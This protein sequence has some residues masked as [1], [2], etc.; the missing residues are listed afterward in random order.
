MPNQIIKFSCNYIKLLALLGLPKE[1]GSVTKAH[2]E[3]IAKDLTR[4]VYFSRKFSSQE[5]QRR[6]QSDTT[7]SSY[8]QGNIDC[9]LFTRL[10]AMQQTSAIIQAAQSVNPSNP[11]ITV[12]HFKELTE[13]GFAFV[14]ENDKD[15]ALAISYHPDV[16][17]YFIICY[18]RNTRAKPEE[19]EVLFY[20][21]SDADYY[22]DVQTLH[23]AHLGEA[24]LL[25]RASQLKQLLAINALPVEVQ[26]L[27]K[28]C[29]NQQGELLLEQIIKLKN[30]L[31]TNNANQGIQFSPEIA[32]A[33]KIEN[34][35]HIIESIF[36]QL[37]VD[38]A[39]PQ[40]DIAAELKLL[41]KR[42]EIVQQVNNKQMRNDRSGY[43]E[44]EQ[45]IKLALIEILSTPIVY[46]V[47]QKSIEGLDNKFAFIYQHSQPHLYQR[48]PL[49]TALS[50]CITLLTIACLSL[51]LTGIL[52][53]IELTLIVASNALLLL[54]VIASWALTNWLSNSN[55]Q[56]AQSENL[57]IQ[58]SLSVAHQLD[59]NLATIEFY[60]EN[61][62]HIEAAPDIP[63]RTEH[64]LLARHAFFKEKIAAATECGKAPSS[65]EEKNQSSS[66]VH[67]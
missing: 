37:P 25:P 39:S 49:T 58:E 26:L 66:Y 18:I 41:L 36:F 22:P 11:R 1:M 12:E 16:P 8:T 15:C 10:T 47:Y 50:S 2:Q 44:Q 63:N 27:L 20:Q 38:P 56:K 67:Q 48:Q 31:L 65:E 6:W 19:R 28:D 29:F 32:A 57:A 45:L 53:P 7:S 33:K 42:I 43:I 54:S 3:Q 61:R 24:Q 13:L 4:S 23:K 17:N 9:K 60:L 64:Y 30:Q 51:S 14:D 46:H 59:N 21:S 35:H 40:H 62:V 55:Q 5:I 52:A 34:Y